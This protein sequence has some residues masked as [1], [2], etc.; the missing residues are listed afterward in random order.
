MIAY[1]HEDVKYAHYGLDFYPGDSNHTVGSFAKLL[2]DFEKL[3]V[4]S[5]RAL[6]DGCG[7]TPL[8]EAMLAGKEICMLS[9]PEP[10]RESLIIEPLITYWNRIH[11]ALMTL[12]GDTRTTLTQGFWPQSRLMVVKSDTMFLSNGDVREEFALDDHYVGHARID[13]HRRFV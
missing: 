12:G 6:F 4:H 8:Y 9:L 1:G 3:P 5:T 11:S 7:T 10:P 2:H 13:R